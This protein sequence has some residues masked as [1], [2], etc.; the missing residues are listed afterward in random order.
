[1]KLEQQGQQTQLSIDM[2]KTTPYKCDECQSEFFEEVICIR[3]ISR[4]LR[5]ASR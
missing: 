4:L 2:D 5:W 3:K 1:M